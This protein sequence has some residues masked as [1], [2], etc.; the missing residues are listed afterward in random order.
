MTPTEVSTLHEIRLSLKTL[1]HSGLDNLRHWSSVVMH[2]ERALDGLARLPVEAHAA[3]A[4]ASDAELDALNQ[5]AQDSAISSGIPPH[6][7]F[8]RAIL[9]RFG[10]L[11]AAPDAQ[12]AEDDEPVAWFAFADNNGPVSLELWGWDKKACL[13]AVLENA[14][15]IGWKGTVNGYL[16]EQRWSVRPVWLHPYAAPDAQ[17]VS[18]NGAVRAALEEYLEAQDALDNREYGG[19]NGE[20][21][22]TAMRRRNGARRDL[23]AA[24]SASQTHGKSQAEAPLKGLAECLRRFASSGYD[25]DSRMLRQWAKEVDAVRAQR[26]PAAPVAAGLSVADAEAM[27]AKGAPATDAERLLFEAWMKGHCWKVVGAWSGDSYTASDEDGSYVNPQATM[28]RRLWAAWRD[29]AALAAAAPASHIE[30]AEVQPAAWL[31]DVTLDA[32]IRSYPWRDLHGARTMVRSAV[33]KF[34]QPSE[35]SSAEGAEPVILLREL[36]TRCTIM[37]QHW[38]PADLR[39]KVDALLAAPVAVEHPDAARLDYLQQR[40]ATVEIVMGK[41]VSAGWEFRVGGRNGSCSRNLR[42]AIDAALQAT[43]EGA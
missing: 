22:E 31:D 4:G 36:M 34:A 41:P 11:P 25:A 14:R 1:R 33:A 2:A 26:Q 39:E 29:R 23:D 43:K 5:Q 35:G 16:L 21:H 38:M 30:T 10:A 28:T 20:T 19:V 24:L 40:G 13:H 18:D 12:A 42:S 27:G 7:A 32:F 8:A 3:P 15:S 17:P 37:P 6:R 9:V